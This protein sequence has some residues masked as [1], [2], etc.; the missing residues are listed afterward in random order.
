[1]LFINYCYFI[2][3]INKILWW[4]FS[5]QLGKEEKILTERYFRSSFRPEPNHWKHTELPCLAWRTLQCLCN[6]YRG[7][8]WDQKSALDIFFVFF[9]HHCKNIWNWHNWSVSWKTQTVNIM[10]TDCSH[11]RLSAGPIVGLQCVIYW[12]NVLSQNRCDL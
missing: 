4:D 9:G 12:I 7:A 5:L 1:M 2:S 6:S 11:S 3:F 10:H 8:W